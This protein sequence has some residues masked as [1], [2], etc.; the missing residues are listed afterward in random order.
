[1]K[2]RIFIGTF[3]I[4]NLGLILYGVIAIIK[5]DILLEPFL[6]HVYQFPPEATGATTYLS[7]LYRLLGY[8]NIIPGV[9]GL[10]LLHRYWATRREWYGRIVV[11]STAL[12]Y[13]GPVVFDNTAGTIGFF[14]ILEHVLFALVLIMGFTMLRWQVEVA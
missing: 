14:E 11:A 7:A 6:T 13:I 9:F 1:M 5:P 10:V 12:S 8:F 3:A 4:A 2:S